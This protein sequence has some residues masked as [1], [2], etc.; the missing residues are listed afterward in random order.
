M[1]DLNSK[2]HNAAITP[3]A[4]KLKFLLTSFVILSAVEVAK[5]CDEHVCVCVCVC[6]WSVRE[7]I[8]GAIHTIFTNFS[9]HVAYG[10]GSV[11]LRQ[12]AEIPRGRDSFGVFLPTDNAMHCI[13]FRTHKKRLNRS[14]CHLG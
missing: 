12:G 14:R 1:G 11:L 5:Y 3:Q 7:H 2:E 8:S 13:A 9:V 6:V 4:L 10:R